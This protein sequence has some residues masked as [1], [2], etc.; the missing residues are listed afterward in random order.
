MAL[1]GNAGNVQ[2]QISSIIR[3]MYVCV[4]ALLAKLLAKFRRQSFN[5]VIRVFVSDIY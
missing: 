4:R 1:S 3:C 2:F 5:A